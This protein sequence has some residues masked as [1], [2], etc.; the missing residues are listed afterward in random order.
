LH[1]RLRMMHRRALSM[2]MCEDG[3]QHVAHEK[4]PYAKSRR[5]SNI[6]AE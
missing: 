3:T 6:F 4:S 1:S 2:R 5:A